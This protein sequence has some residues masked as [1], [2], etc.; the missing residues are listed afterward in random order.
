MLTITF[1]LE[2]YL[3]TKRSEVYRL[4]GQGTIEELIYERQGRF[5]LCFFFPNAASFSDICCNITVQKQQS[6]RQLN[7]GTL[8]PRI[9]QGYDRATNAKDQAE[10]FGVH[11]LFHF[12]PSGFAPANV[13][14]PFFIP[15]G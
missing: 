12:D 6:A 1:K 10:L 2:L 3:I 4:I 13:R 15:L 8:E 14:P 11:N 5:S 7:N 9:Y